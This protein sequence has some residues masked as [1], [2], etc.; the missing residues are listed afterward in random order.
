[1]ASNAFAC[2]PPPPPPP[3]CSPDCG[4]WPHCYARC[5]GGQCCEV[6]TCCG[7]THCC[8]QGNTCC[9]GNCCSAASCTTCVDGHCVSTCIGCQECVGGQCRDSS[10]RC[11]SPCERCVGGNCVSSCVPANCETCV[12]GVCKVCE[13][14]PSR[15]CCNGHL[16]C[17]DAYGTTCC[18]SE[19]CVNAEKTCCNGDHCCSN[20]TICCGSGCCPKNCYECVG[21]VCK[22]CDEIPGKCCNAIGLCV[23]KCDPTGASC[24]HDTPGIQAGCQRQGP[25]NFQC[26]PNQVGQTCLWTLVYENSSSAKCADCA[27][28]CSKAIDPSQPYCA[29]YKAETCRNMIG[30]GCVCNYN[31]DEGCRPTYGDGTHYICN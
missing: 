16:P 18:G 15:F 31:G 13:G 1:M 12:G 23:D 26:V 7:T 25:T 17:C 11:I 4:S 5:P 6:G 20:D 21:G 14:D 8:A 29:F 27:P 3:S 22:T 2:A 30:I 24:P 10:F 19:C 9:D 28:G